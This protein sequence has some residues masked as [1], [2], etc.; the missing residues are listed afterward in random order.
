MLQQFCQIP[1]KT[2]KQAA[3]V[4]L[5]LSRSEDADRMTEG[6]HDYHLSRS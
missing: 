3:D 1:Q 4:N 2:G 5:N 6:T